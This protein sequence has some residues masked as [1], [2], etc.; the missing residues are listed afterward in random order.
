MLKADIGTCGAVKKGSLFN[1]DPLKV[2][3]VTHLKTFCHLKAYIGVQS[4]FA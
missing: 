3:L 4:R 2:T 1:L